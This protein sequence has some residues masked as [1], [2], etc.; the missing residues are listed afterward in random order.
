[1]LRLANKPIQRAWKI[2]AYSYTQSLTIYFSNFATGEVA[3]LPYCTHVSLST[4][5]M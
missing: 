3:S 2:L 5:V 1:M 4:F